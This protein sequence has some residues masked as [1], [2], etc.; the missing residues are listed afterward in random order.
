M[1][2]NT[3]ITEVDFEVFNSFIDLSINSLV[4]SGDGGCR[5]Q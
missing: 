4:R 3:D 1:T 5:K 2:F